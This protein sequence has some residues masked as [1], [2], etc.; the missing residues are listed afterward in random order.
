MCSA[1]GMSRIQAILN[2]F[3]LKCCSFAMQ[4]NEH[5]QTE[6]FMLG[7][8]RQ[9]EWNGRCVQQGKI[10]SQAEKWLDVLISF[11]TQIKIKIIILKSKIYSII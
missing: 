6:S 10:R 5:Q 11:A 9:R 2:S 8:E 7:N 4:R 3:V 1:V